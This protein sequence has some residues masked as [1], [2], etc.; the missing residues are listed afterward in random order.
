M[1]FQCRGEK[2][3]GI[4]C[5][6]AQGLI[7]SWSCDSGV[8]DG[9]SWRCVKKFER[10]VVSGENRGLGVIASWRCEGDGVPVEVDEYSVCRGASREI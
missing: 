10:V 2:I 3:T 6:S 5:L 4:E 9:G 7:K 1:C 8:W